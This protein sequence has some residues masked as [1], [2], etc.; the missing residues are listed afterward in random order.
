MVR[1]VQG[2]ISTKAF[3]ETWSYTTA[4]H[5]YLMGV[6]DWSAVTGVEDLTLPTCN[7]STGSSGPP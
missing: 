5:R 4:N 3:D 1:C 2:L 7:M 6:C